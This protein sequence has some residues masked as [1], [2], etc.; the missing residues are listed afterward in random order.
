MK[1]LSEK[2]GEGE[3]EEGD[4]DEEEDSRANQSQGKPRM[5]VE[6]L[7]GVSGQGWCAVGKVHCGV[8][9]SWER[10][11]SLRLSC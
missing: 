8:W 4:D 2:E 7:E 6:E 9:E 10:L 11:S 1:T 3:E 5:G